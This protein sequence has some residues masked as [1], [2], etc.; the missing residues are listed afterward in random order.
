MQKNREI[1]LSIRD[2]VSD[3]FSAPPTDS[4]FSVFNVYNEID[5][6]NPDH[7]PTPNTAFIYLVDSYQL[8]VNTKLPLVVLEIERYRKESFELG[9][10]K[11]RNIKAHIHVFGRNRGERDDLAGFMADYFGDSFDI[12]TYTQAS[13]TGTVVETVQLNDRIDV[14]DMTISGPIQGR[15]NVESS[16]VVLDWSRVS[17]EFACKL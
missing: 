14:S 16:G 15:E 11:G 13:P 8:P 4:G 5:Y 6:R 3:L 10:R 1:R 17:F 2:R 9:N 12:K 7:V